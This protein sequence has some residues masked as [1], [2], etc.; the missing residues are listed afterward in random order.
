MDTAA[1]RG[2]ALV[3]DQVEAAALYR[4][5]FSFPPPLFRR[6]DLVFLWQVLL[7]EKDINPMAPF[8]TELPKFVADP[9]YHGS[10]ASI[11]VSFLSLDSDLTSCRQPSST[12]VTAAISLTSSA[13]RRFGSS[14][15]RK[16]RLLSLGRRST[17]VLLLS[18]PFPA[19]V[20]LSLSAAPHRLPRPAFLRRDLHSHPLQRFQTLP[21]KRCSLP[22][23]RKDRG[24]PGEGVQEVLE[25]PGGAEEGGGGEGG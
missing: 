19:P 23:V 13:R 11:R 18:S 7:S 5:R 16:R 25:G 8:E 6:S 24:R 14:V 15:R 2:P 12:T 10:S 20:N 4:V 22:R 1:A 3:V 17:C 21:P 9:R